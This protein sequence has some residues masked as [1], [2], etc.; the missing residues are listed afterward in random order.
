VPSHDPSPA[1]PAPITV[2]WRPG[3]GYC[4]SLLR[5]LDRL[6]VEF[7]AI[8]IWQNPDAA[9]FVRSVARGYETVPTVSVGEH[10][11]VNPSAH[12]V[13]ELAGGPAR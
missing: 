6:G 4:S 8:D 1:A 10:H 5:G 12:E 11:L 7:E 13:A 2:Y 3:C 9:A